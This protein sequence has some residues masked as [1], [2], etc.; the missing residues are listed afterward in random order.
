MPSTFFPTVEE[1]LALHA[2]LIERYGG[3]GGVRDLGVLDAALHRPRSGYYGSLSE[4]AGALL[5]SLANGNAFVDG[6][7]RVA[8][9]TMAIFL[10]INGFELCATADEAEAFLVDEVIRGGAPL[11]EIASWLEAHMHEKK[12]T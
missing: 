4:Q 1:V 9:A 11:P 12:Q 3:H 10:R 2:M 8:F 7:K 6:N 5:Q